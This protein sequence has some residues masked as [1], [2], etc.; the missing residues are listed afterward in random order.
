[1]EKMGITDIHTHILYGV[2][3]GAEYLGDSMKLI[4]E[5][6]DQGVQRIILTPH[7]GPKFGHPDRNI[8]EQRFHEIEEETKKYYPDMK[9]YLGSELYYQKDTIQ[10]LKDGKAL[11]M[12]GTRYI[13][14]E[15]GIRDS[16][17]RIF[18][19]VQN[20]VYAGF[21]PIIAH[22]ERYEAVFG[23]IDKAKDLVKAGA[24]L[25]VN[26]ESFLG[27][28]L[29]KRTA[30]CKKLLKEQLI[31]FVGSDCHDMTNRRPDMKKGLEVVY[32]KFGDY[33]FENHADK[34]V[35]GEYI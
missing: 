7:Y 16:Y 11:T 8:L 5:E 33:N 17:S 21:L 31:C 29:D 18:Q 15:F 3:D 1:M 6:W 28:F 32:K 26:T 30:F 35:R 19:A 24:Y 27:G 23:H 2:D 12:A 10:D 13:L 9:L 20:M 4:A 14:V 25:Q 34:I 22:V